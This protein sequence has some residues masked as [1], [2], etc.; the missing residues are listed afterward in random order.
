M[1]GLVGTSKQAGEAQD[2]LLSS[3]VKPV[4]KTVIEFK[5]VSSSSSQLSS[6]DKMQRL[7]VNDLDREQGMC[8]CRYAPASCAVMAL[9]WQG[10][11][12]LLRVLQ[13]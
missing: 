3:K 4:M 5:S 11:S 13:R 8:M 2:V 9:M 12:C 10:G 6:G 1:T 7:L